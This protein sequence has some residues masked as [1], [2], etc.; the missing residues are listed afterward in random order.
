MRGKIS[1]F[2]GPGDTGMTKEE[3]LSLYEH[4]EANKRPDLFVTRSQ[5]LREGTSQRLRHD[6]MYFAFRFHRPINREALQRHPWLFTN[7]KTGAKVVLFL[8]DW[9]PHERTGRVFDISPRAAQLL[10]V[11]TDDELDGEP[12]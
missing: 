11:K 7:P 2:G 5:D 10:G 1:T 9:G 4:D 6:G 8:C 3:G 12:I